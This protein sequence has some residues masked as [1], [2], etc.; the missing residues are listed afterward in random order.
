L[1]LLS[2]VCSRIGQMNSEPMSRTSLA[3][4]A[5]FVHM[6][7]ALGKWLLAGAPG[8]V[9]VAGLSDGWDCSYMPANTLAMH[10]VVLGTEC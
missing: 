9:S 4:Q 5:M 6:A 2:S 8:S 7:S 3:H 1:G 10:N